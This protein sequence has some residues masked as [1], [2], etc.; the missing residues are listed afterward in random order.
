MAVF[1]FTNKNYIVNLMNYLNIFAYT[2][3]NIFLNTEKDIFL[4]K[5]SEQS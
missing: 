4:F 5:S 2:C 3:L 1:H